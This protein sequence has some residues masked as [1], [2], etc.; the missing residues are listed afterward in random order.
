LT[1]DYIP[2][3]VKNVVVEVLEKNTPIIT[4]EWVQDVY[5]HFAHCYSVDGI[6]RSVNKE[7]ATICFGKF[8]KNAE[9]EVD[10]PKTHHLAHLFITKFFPDYPV[11]TDIIK[12][13]LPT[14]S[15]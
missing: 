3:E 13:G 7:G 15:E 4:E 1:V 5:R 6:E 11:R 9:E 12:R 8:W 14:E 10:F 2:Q